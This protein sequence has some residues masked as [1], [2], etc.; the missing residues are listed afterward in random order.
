M[1]DGGR[2]MEGSLLVEEWPAKE[3]EEEEVEWWRTGGL[4]TAPSG[5]VEEAYPIGDTAVVCVEGLGFDLTAESMEASSEAASDCSAD[6]M[7]GSPE[8]V[9]EHS[10]E[11]MDEGL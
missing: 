1:E 8:T 7:A 6:S 4:E 10:A 11:S 5:E 3:L 2:N 9:C